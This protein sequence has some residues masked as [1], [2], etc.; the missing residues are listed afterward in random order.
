MKV[1]TK[2]PML[3]MSNSKQWKSNSFL[4]NWVQSILFAAEPSQ[5]QYPRD[6]R[7]RGHIKGVQHSRVKR[8]WGWAVLGLHSSQAC[9]ATQLTVTEQIA[10][11]TKTSPP[12]SA[13]VLPLHPTRTEFHLLKCLLFHQYIGSGGE[14]HSA[15]SIRTSQSKMPCS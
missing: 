14:S 3:I 13:L 6:E 7:R 8:P 4:C 2:S 5:L 11:E 15:G 1:Y 9:G 10:A 12:P